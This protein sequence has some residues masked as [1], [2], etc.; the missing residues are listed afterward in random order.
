MYVTFRRP[1]LRQNTPQFPFLKH[2]NI[3]NRYA[4][5]KNVQY[6]FEITIKLR[7]LNLMTGRATFISVSKAA[8]VTSK[9]KKKTYNVTRVSFEF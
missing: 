8:H 2:K 3:K 9:K 5:Y 1:P 7:D 4:K 6:T